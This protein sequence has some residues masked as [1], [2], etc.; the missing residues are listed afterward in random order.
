M[1]KEESL[2]DNNG[3]LDP[4]ELATGQYQSSGRLSKNLD[5]IVELSAGK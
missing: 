5:I 1:A 3:L 4:E 2:D